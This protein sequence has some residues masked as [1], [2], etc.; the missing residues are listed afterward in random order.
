MQASVHSL[1]SQGNIHA[2]A[3]FSE[4]LVRCSVDPN[5]G[6]ICLLDA[7]NG[8]SVEAVKYIIALH[9]A[10][11]TLPAAVAH[12]GKSGNTAL[13]RACRWSR[14]DIA[15]VLLQAGASPDI[16]NDWIQYPLHI[17]V[18]RQCRGCVK[19]LLKFNANIDV[20]D[21]KNRRPE[22]DNRDLP[23]PCTADEDLGNLIRAHR[24]RLGM[25]V[26]SVPNYCEGWY[27]GEIEGVKSV[28]RQD[29]TA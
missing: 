14:H 23:V 10:A 8:G 17:S 4:E 19:H 22:G 27:G 9:Q 26:T 13:H 5:T 29:R 21:R 24:Q 2:L 1:A 7:A 15:L 11:G 28:P 12:V 18:F 16:P 3:Q 25:E 6:N 20:V